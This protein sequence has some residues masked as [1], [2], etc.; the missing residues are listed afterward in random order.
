MKK[1]SIVSPCYNEEKNLHQLCQEVRDI[2]KNELSNY[3]YE[4]I[5][6]DN[7]STDGSEIILRDLAKS[8]P[9]IKVIINSRNF[10]HLR[11][12]MHGLMQST[13]DA[14]ILLVSDLQDPPKLIIDL[15]KKWE[16]G[17]DTVICIK[18]ESEESAVM[19]AIRSLYYNLINKISE[20]K[21]EKNY[22]GFG[23]YDKKII[24]LLKCFDDPYPYFR[25]LIFKIGFKIDRIYYVQPKRKRG[26]TSNN[27]YTLYDLAMLGICTH[28]KVPLRFFTISG[29][30]IAIF[31][32]IVSLAYLIMKLI[33]W[34]SFQLGLAPII[35]GLFFFS[36]IQIFSIGI[37]GEYLGVIL[38]K[39]TKEP[40]AI[41]KERINF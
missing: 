3:S 37:I 22:T 8:D 36:A 26:V 11:S 9:N 7:A 15:V 31:S 1:I 18:K 25:G 24:N 28:S 16:A 21:L 30:F 17:N 38:T 2:F 40:L 41:E 10:G 5:L 4:H 14:T 32:L 19:F 13:G 29:F 23:L 20:T 33:F 12:P 39:I 35:I 34:N 27:F 6:I